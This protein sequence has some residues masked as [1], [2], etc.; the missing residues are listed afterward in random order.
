MSDDLRYITLPDPPLGTEANAGVGP[1]DV[2][3]ANGLW[4]DTALDLNTSAS[5]PSGD[6]TM[7]MSPESLGG[8]SSSALTSGADAV[9]DPTF[10]AN[11]YIRPDSS[12]DTIPAGARPEVCVSRKY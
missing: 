9:A 1:S 10:D 11:D 2:I 7:G 6:V 8:V 5:L 12:A 3:G 4:P